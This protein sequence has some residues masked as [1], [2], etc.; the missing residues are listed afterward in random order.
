M[1]KITK[2]PHA[3]QAF[4]D[5]PIPR[6]YQRNPDFDS[7]DIDDDYGEGPSSLGRSVVTPGEI[8]TNSKEYMRYVTAFYDDYES[9]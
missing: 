5:D 1:F 3:H 9:H 2:A 4:S 7:M 6:A 8:I